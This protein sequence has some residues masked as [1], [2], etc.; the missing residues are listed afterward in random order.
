VTVGE[1]TVA[2]AKKVTLQRLCVLLPVTL[3]SVQE[4]LA[5]VPADA[6]HETLPAGLLGLPLAMSVAVAVH[7]LA[8]PIATEDGTQLTL[9]EVER[10]TVNV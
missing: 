10:L 4:A 7:V 5:N 2:G 3:A 8:L 6:V 9:V 1:P